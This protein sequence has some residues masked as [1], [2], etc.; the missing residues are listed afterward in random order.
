MSKIK[1]LFIPYT[2]TNGGGAEK[3]LSLLVNNLDSEKYDIRIQEVQR[4]ENTI[5]LNKNIKMG[6]TFFDNG[7]S[8][9]IRM[10]RRCFLFLLC[11]VPF[12]LKRLFNLQGYDV[13]I[14][15][16]YQLPSFML[17]AFK[18]E[19]KIA[20]FHGDIYDLNEAE[21]IKAKEKQR[22]AWQTAD[23]IVTISNKSLHSLEVLFPEFMNKAKIIHNGVNLENAIKLSKENCDFNFG[24]IPT[25][26]CLGRFDKNKNFSLVIDSVSA[27]K[28]R[29]IE[30]QLILLGEGEKE[31][32][33]K[34]QVKTLELSERVF[35]LGYQTNPYSYI[36]RSK[37]LCIS[38]YSEGF[39]TVALEAMALGIPFV[40]TPV[41]GASEE[42]SDNEK[43]GLV[44]DRNAEE[45]AD[46]LQKLLTDSE[47]YEQM[48]K[49]CLEHV[50]DYSVEQ[51][52]SAFEKLLSDLGVGK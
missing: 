16:N 36:A 18:K 25:F 43:C 31:V 28:K 10:K 52:V 30:C 45:Y 19:K 3:V 9:Q 47:L 44:S 33:L 27:L 12:V 24:T 23:A 15:F 37:V 34:K 8:F 35:F 46:K 1:L 21:K 51:Y 41:S 42:L 39:P 2:M 49:N 4:Y 40:T 29:G 17:P 20:W 11:H 5:N 13:V 26:I 32:E 7:K 38:S 50:K 48:S 14:S 22:K 6:D